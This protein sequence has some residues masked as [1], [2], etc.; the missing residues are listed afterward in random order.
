VNRV[1]QRYFKPSNRTMTE[2]VPTEHPDRAEIPA[3]VD[4]TP[5]VK[6]Y[7]GDQAL[8]AGE[9]FEATPKN[10]ESHTTR[11]ALKNGLKVALLPK[12]TR[13]E[14]VHLV[15]ELDYGT[16]ASLF[17]KRQVGYAAASMVT[18]GTLKKTRQQFKDEL[19]KLRVALTVHPQPQGVVVSME[20]RKPQLGAAL[21]LVA[22]ALKEPR[23]D[24]KEFESMRREV[25][26]Q[27]EQEKDDPNAIGFNTLTQ[28]MSPFPKGHPL[29][30]PS[31]DEVIADAT[32]MKLDEAKDFQARFY[33]AQDGQVAVVGDFDPKAVTEKLEALFGGFVAKEKYERIPNP[34][35]AMEKKEATTQT[36]DKAMAFYGAA[37]N[38][39]MKDTDPE[40]PAMLMADYLLGGGF[41]SGRVPKRLREKEGWS[42]GAGTSLH[43]D[44]RDDNAFLLGYAI[45]A[46]QNTDKADA[47]FHDEVQK[48]TDKGFTDEELKLGKDGLLQQRQQE[49]ANDESLAADLAN[50][51][52][53]GRT[54]EFEDKLDQSLK[55]LALKDV[56][57]ALKKHVDAS[58]FTTVKAGDFK[59]IAAPK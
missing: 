15:M 36:P 39:K 28:L 30:V 20:V 35:V 54:M 38:F 53:V 10:I 24:P 2:Y 18:R 43:V 6:G 3:L 41:L 9:A 31:F 48:A 11:T 40:Y 44:E 49:L 33:G 34:Y 17:G 51:L 42:Y 46:P 19:D 52:D 56:N 8:A 5:V 29:S 45:E 13:G 50:N 22:E 47:A 1:A 59:K 12:K 55:G 57:A 27:V 32:A 16:A 14:T 26:A 58:R 7:T 37:E 23:F 25:L 4:L 21:D